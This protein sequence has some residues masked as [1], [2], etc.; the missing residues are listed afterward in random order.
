MKTNMSVAMNMY[1]RFIVDEHKVELTPVYKFGGLNG[2][3]IEVTFKD[4]STW[5]NTFD[6]DT[7]KNGKLNWGNSE[8]YE[9]SIEFANVGNDSVDIGLEISYIRKG[10]CMLW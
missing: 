2:M 5:S 8:N 10:G 3:S 1:G 4:G 7:M 6:K 9:I